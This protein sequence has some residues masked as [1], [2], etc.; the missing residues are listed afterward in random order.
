MDHLLREGVKGAGKEPLVIAGDFNTG[1]STWVVTYTS[2]KSR[3]V[4]DAT[5]KEGL[6]LLMDAEFLTRIATSTG[7]NKCPY[8]TLT[9]N[10]KGSSWRNLDEHLAITQW[11]RWREHRGRPE[12]TVENVDE[13]MRD[14]A[15]SRWLTPSCCTFGKAG[16]LS[17]SV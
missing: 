12:V 9:K 15:G 4:A 6:T 7:R 11:D 3:K 1:N 16:G 2:S 14:L 8:L 13:W 5:S 17:P 10:I